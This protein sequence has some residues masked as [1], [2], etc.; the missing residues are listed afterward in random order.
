MARCQ[1]RGK[2]II[3]LSQRPS[4]NFPKVADSSRDCMTRTSNFWKECKYDFDV[5]IALPAAT[6]WLG[7]PTISWR[8]AKVHD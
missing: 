7:S 5:G 8:S 4:Q 6:P 2:I 3:E 1:P